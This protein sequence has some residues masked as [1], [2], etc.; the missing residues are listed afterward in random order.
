M[1]FLNIG[2][3]YKVESAPLMFNT[4]SNEMPFDRRLQRAAKK[5]ERKTERKNISVK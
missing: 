4:F 2:S 5:K 1:W 3:F